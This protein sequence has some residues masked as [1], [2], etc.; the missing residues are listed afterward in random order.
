MAAIEKHRDRPSRSSRDLEIEVKRK[1][2][3][4]SKC[5]NSGISQPAEEK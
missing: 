2:R 1:V 5:L 3:K 4:S